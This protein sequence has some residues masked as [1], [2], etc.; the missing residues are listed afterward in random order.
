MARIKIVKV[1]KDCYEFIDEDFSCNSMFVSI[2]QMKDL[3]VDAEKVLNE[4]CESTDNN[5]L[6]NI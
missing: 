2:C 4:I 1:D 3:I 5:A 6:N